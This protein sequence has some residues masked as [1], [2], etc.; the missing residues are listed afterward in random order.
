MNE[1]KEVMDLY[2]FIYFI[3]NFMEGCPSAEAG[4]QGAIPQKHLLQSVIIIIIMKKAIFMQANL[5]SKM[6]LLLSTKGL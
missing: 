1:L 4:F 2:I 5:F 6:N 3:F